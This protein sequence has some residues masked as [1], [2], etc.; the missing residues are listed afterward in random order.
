MIAA[1]HGALPQVAIFPECLDVIILEM[2][3]WL[4]SLALRSSAPREPSLAYQ[5]PPLKMVEVR[6]SKMNGHLCILFFEN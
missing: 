3:T 2:A 4:M 5:M 6:E 1:M